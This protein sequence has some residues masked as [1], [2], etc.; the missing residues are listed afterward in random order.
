MVTQPAPPGDTMRHAWLL[1]V[2][3]EPENREE[4]KSM[5]SKNPEFPLKLSHVRQKCEAFSNSKLKISREAY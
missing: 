2:R 5:I 1:V 3:L 4:K